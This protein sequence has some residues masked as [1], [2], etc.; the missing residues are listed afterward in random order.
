MSLATPWATKAATTTLWKAGPQKITT[1]VLELD[2]M[3]SG[4]SVT[5]FSVLRAWELWLCVVHYLSLTGFF[6]ED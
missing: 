1:Q 2:G 6:L 3:K 5:V 4:Q